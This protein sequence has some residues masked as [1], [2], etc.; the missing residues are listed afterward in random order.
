MLRR[1]GA[2]ARAEASGHHDCCESFGITGVE[3]LGRQDSNLGSRDQNP[4]PYHL[5]TPQRKGRRS[6]H[7]HAAVEE[8]QDQRERPRRCR[9]PRGR[10]SHDDAPAMHGTST[11][12][13]CETAAIQMTWR[14]RRR[15][16]LAAQRRSRASTSD[17]EGDDDHEPAWDA[18]ASDEQPLDDRDPECDLEPPFVRASG[19]RGSRRARSRRVARHA[20]QPYQ[21]GTV[22][23]GRARRRSARA[24][25]AGVALGR[26]EPVDG[27]AGAA[28]VGAERPGARS[29]SASG[30]DARSF[31]GRRARSRGRRTRR[32]RRAAPRARSSKPSRAAAR[33]ERGVD[34][35]RSTPSRAPCG[36]TS[37]TQ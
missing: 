24:A 25:S 9:R 35:A 2:H 7:V 5:A 37:T 32:A 13:A 29:S 15:S 12:S 34:V 30:E 23:P 27:R 6:L 36:S 10:A 33:V 31:G 8:E 26:E 4:L 16:A 18:P 21:A 11:T 14:T 22:D 1:R 3:W 20:R 17:R 28:D 19:R